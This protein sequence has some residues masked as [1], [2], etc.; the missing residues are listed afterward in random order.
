MPDPA[1]PRPEPPPDP[2]PHVVDGEVLSLADTMPHP[3]QYPHAVREA[4][5]V[6]PLPDVADGHG[7]GS[8]NRGRRG[9]SSAGARRARWCPRRG[10]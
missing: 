4:R 10:R 3:L 5:V 1:A 8:V 6:P 2:I 7:V 9:P